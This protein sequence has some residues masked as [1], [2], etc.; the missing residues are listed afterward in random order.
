MTLP[1]CWR[2]RLG[3][4]GCK[5]KCLQAQGFSILQAETHPNLQRL[6][7]EAKQTHP[8]SE[9]SLRSLWWQRCLSGKR[10]VPEFGVSRARL[11]VFCRTRCSPASGKYPIARVIQE[12]KR[13]DGH[14]RP[15]WSQSLWAKKRRHFAFAVACGD[16]KAPWSF[17]CF[18]IFIL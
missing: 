1:L 2:E 9:V 3:I 11:A 5:Q 17:K 13:M 16:T 15:R 6:E 8:W 12:A 10:G 14:S 7:T 4:T 18:G